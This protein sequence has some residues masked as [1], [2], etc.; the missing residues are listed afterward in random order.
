MLSVGEPSGDRLGAGLA[1]AL[2]RRRP[3]IELLGMGGPQMEA[4]GVRL[5]Q[6]MT[7]VSVVGLVEVVSHL[8]ALRRAMARLV[9]GLHGERP[10]LLVPIDFPDFNLRLAARAR[11]A[12][13]PVVY[14]VSPQ[15]WA[16]RRGRVRRIRSLV[17]RMLVLF[18]FETA[19]YERA[20]VPV[21]FVGHPMAESGAGEARS[22]EELC[23]RARLDPA[24]R[25]VA[26]LPGS[27]RGEVSRLLPILLDTV[28]L[29]E[30]GERDLQYLIPLAAGLPRETVD[31]HLTGATGEF[32]I[33]QGDFPEV[34]GVC[35]AGLVAAGTASLEAAVVGLPMAVFYRVSRLSHLVGRL[36]VRLDHV[37]LPN[38]VAGRRV[39]PELIQRDCVPERLAGELTRLLDDAGERSRMRESL[40]EVRRQLGG[41]GVYDRAAD[42]ILGELVC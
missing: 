11:S 30:R 36:M 23:A 5:I 17:R 9:D 41:P 27:R 8:P 18:P 40:L 10:D 35:E 38:L 32:V 33:H 26:L 42:A 28:R 14:F 15:I 24:R 12:G 4:A 20:G 25:I 6:Q 37:A 13:V 3:H 22:R 2:R 19:L 1:R 21:S 31:R 34:L 16:W 29:V 7:E 39:V